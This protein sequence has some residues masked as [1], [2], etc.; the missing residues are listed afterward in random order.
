MINSKTK[1]EKIPPPSRAFKSRPET[2]RTDRTQALGAELSQILTSTAPLV[3]EIGCGVG[4]HPIQYAAAFPSK[5]IIAIE[6]TAEKFARFAS[7]LEHHPELQKNLC[8]INADAVHFL[9]RNLKRNSI[10]EVWILYPNPESKKTSR[11]WFQ[12]P[13]MSRLT[14]FMK[15]G[16]SLYFATNLADYADEAMSLA[17]NHHLRLSSSLQVDRT[18]HPEW[19]ARTH[20][21]KKYHDRGETLFDLVFKFDPIGVPR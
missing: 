3:V 7:R 17:P 12:M 11:R 2:D 1:S 21:E 15:P 8:A 14:E 18:S 9:D 13:F 16:A 5:N 6:R 20:F 10:D 19:K 4:L